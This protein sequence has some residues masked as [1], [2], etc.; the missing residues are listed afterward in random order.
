M[1]RRVGT[2]ELILL[3]AFMTATGAL[4]IDQ[5]LPAFPEMRLHFGLDEDSTRLSLA[6]TLFFVGA[7]IEAGLAIVLLAIVL[8]RMTQAYGEKIQERNQPVKK[9]KKSN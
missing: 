7:A 5:M 8:D 3:V 6:V 9:I 4:A 2:G 1:N